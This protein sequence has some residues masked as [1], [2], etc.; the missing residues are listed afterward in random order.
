M[1]E[2]IGLYRGKRKDNGEW[3]EGFL[4]PITVNCYDKGYE[5]IGKG[6]IYYD[7]LDCYHSFCSERVIPETVGQFTGLTDKNGKKIFEGDILRTP[8]HPEDDVFIVWGEGRFNFRH[9]EERS[10]YNSLCCVQQTVERM[11]VIGNIHD[12]P[13]LLQNT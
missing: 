7:E 13:E 3:V 12:N 6:G 1:R 11:K 10:Y 9:K 2:N 4:V 8:Y 5:I